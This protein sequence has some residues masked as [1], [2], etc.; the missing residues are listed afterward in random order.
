M[1]VHALV[2]THARIHAHMCFNPQTELKNNV[3]SSLGTSAILQATVYQ[4][5]VYSIST[6]CKLN[7]GI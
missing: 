6:D 7:F 1:H 4:V 5:F 2:H 3:K